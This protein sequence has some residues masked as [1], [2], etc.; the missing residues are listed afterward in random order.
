MLVGDLDEVALYVQ[1]VASFSDTHVVMTACVHFIFCYCVA[2]S[3]T[4][5]PSIFC[6]CVAF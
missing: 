1:C 3:L 2:L 4:P 5:G 6:Y